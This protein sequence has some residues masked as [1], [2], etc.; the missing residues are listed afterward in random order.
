VNCSGSIHPCSREQV[1]RLTRAAL[2]RDLASGEAIGLYRLLEPSSEDALGRGYVA[3]HPRLGTRVAVKVLAREPARSPEAVERFFCE[4]RA[5]NALRHERIV[6]ILDL[7]TLDD[8]SAFVVTEHL[9]GAP[10][11]RLLEERGPLPPAV[12]HR[13][14]G[15][16]GAASWLVLLAGAALATAAARD[17]GRTGGRAMDTPGASYPRSNPRFRRCRGAR[18][19]AV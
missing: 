16:G 8:G 15:Q 11:A 17:A 19:L 7:G 10:L 2:R 13:R 12:L 18:R 1:G 4:A 9:G 14:R 3:E 5:V 6:E